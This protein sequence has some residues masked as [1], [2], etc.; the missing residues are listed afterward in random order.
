VKVDGIEPAVL[1]KV[2][3]QT[4]RTRVEQPAG[5]RADPAVKRRRQTVGQQQYRLEDQSY[6]EKL[7]RE[8]DRLN[9][10][11][12]LYNIGLRFSIHKE[13]ERMMVQ[14]YDRE[15]QRGYPGDT[16]GEGAEPGGPDSTD[17][18]PVAG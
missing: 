6:L 9:K 1:Q 10:T 3:E 5:E 11:A 12:D 8:V 13:T 18:R 2:Q 17:D 7:Q 16:A 14:V 4:R 15:G